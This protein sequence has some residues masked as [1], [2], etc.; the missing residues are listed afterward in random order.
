MK[1][2]TA[3]Y[4]SLKSIYGLGGSPGVIDL[5]DY[6]ELI[7]T[8]TTLMGLEKNSTTYIIMFGEFLKL[9][10]FCC[11]IAVVMDGDVINSNIIHSYCLAR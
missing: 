7:F 11:C 6:S 1:Y 3:L 4:Q 10:Y 2:N 9:N 8:Q 5:A